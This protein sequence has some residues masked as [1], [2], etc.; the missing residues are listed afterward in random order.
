M[1]RLWTLTGSFK[2]VKDGGQDYRARDGTWGG[3]NSRSWSLGPQASHPPSK[4]RI[5]TD[6][7]DGWGVLFSP[8]ATKHSAGA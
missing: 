5:L 7:E 3:S 1:W 4:E 6:L 2:P 8:P